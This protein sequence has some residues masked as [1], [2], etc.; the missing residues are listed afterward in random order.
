T[1][2]LADGL[3]LRLLDLQT[4]VPFTLEDG[5]PRRSI[6]AC[7]PVV[8]ALG[9]FV[10]GGLPASPD[11]VELP[12]AAPA[13]AIEDS[14]VLPA[15]VRAPPT[16]LPARRLDAAV[17]YVTSMPPPSSI[18]VAAA[19]SGRPSLD[20]DAG[21]ESEG[22]APVA[23][24]ERPWARVTLRHRDKSASVD[25]GRAAL[26]VGVLIGRLPTCHD[27][28]LL[29]VL[30]GGIS[31]GHV[32]LFRHHDACEAFDLCSTQGTFLGARRVRRVRL[33][34]GGTALQ[35]ASKEPVALEWSGG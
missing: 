28:R 25:L 33:D 19:R 15:S 4:G 14:A 26:E 24:P 30:N 35:L 22:N 21:G 7:G 29:D 9:S 23:E 20:F 11:G 2:E 16:L 1:I 34:P 6:V 18:V 31:R 5:A 8:A 3:A 32:L 27:A 17:S 13:L 12:D 10:V